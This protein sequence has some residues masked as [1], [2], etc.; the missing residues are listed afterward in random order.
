MNCQLKREHTGKLHLFVDGVPAQGAFVTGINFNNLDNKQYVQVSI[1][2]DKIS[3]AELDN[4]VPFV[5]AER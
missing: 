1:P 3:F 2:L 4:V 5:R